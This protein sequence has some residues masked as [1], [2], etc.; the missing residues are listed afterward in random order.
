MPFLGTVR[1][2]YTP[3]VDMLLLSRAQEQSGEQEIRTSQKIYDLH[4][5]QS[6]SSSS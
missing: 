1:L 2:I 4:F 3:G 5:G 6:F